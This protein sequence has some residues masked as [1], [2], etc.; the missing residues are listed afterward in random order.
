MKRVLRAISLAVLVAGSWGC[1]DDR[2]SAGSF[3]PRSIPTAAEVEEGEPAAAIVVPAGTKLR[4]VLRQAVSSDKSHAG[5]RFSAS[6]AE[7]VIV[8]GKTVVEKGTE[9]AGRVVDA[10]ESGRVN[11]RASLKLRL[12]EIVGD[13]GKSISIST[14][15]YTVIAQSTKKRDAAII[16]GGAGVGAAIGAIAGGKKGAAIGAAVGGGSGTG[17]VL[18]T[19]GKEVRFGP[20]HPLSFTLANAL[21][22]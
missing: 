17:A 5:D 1:N 18:A 22:I 20:E 3:Q 10:T 4:V 2:P 7:P 15:P 14:K 21:E 6:L 8:D 9:V 13:G 16:G 12:T 11:G 19:K